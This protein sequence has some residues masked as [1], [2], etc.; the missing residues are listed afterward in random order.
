MVSQ[1]LN[2]P[3]KE[4]DWIIPCHFHIIGNLLSLQ[5]TNDVGPNKRMPW[6]GQPSNRY[7]FIDWLAVRIME[8]QC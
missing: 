4:R 1:P 3:W 7:L 6:V 2:W 5:N 8:S